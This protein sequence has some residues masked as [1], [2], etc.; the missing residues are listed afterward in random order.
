MRASDLLKPAPKRGAAPSEPVVTNGSLPGGVSLR[1]QT[2]RAKRVGLWVLVGLLALL[3]VRGLV[4]SWGGPRVVIRDTAAASSRFPNADEQA[5]AA[6]F[7]MAWLTFSPGED[8][9]KRADALKGM[10]DPR[11]DAE[12][13]REVPD[14]GKAMRAVAAWPAEATGGCSGRGDCRGA[15]KVQVLTRVQ[16]H[17]MATLYLG[18]PIARSSGGALVV[19]AVPGFV[20]PPAAAKGLPE[21]PTQPLNDDAIEGLV[22]RFLPVFLSGKPVLPELLLC[23]S[24]PP[25]PLGHAWELVE[26]QSVEQVMV[27]VPGPPS[28]CAAGGPARSVVTTVRARDVASGVVFTLRYTIVVA[29][30]TGINGRWL[31]KQV[32]V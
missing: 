26:V 1:R 5:V 18:V 6:R 19:P 25:V 21:L 17:G 31:V 13:A 24:S 14:G 29:R 2:T 12:S 16:G 11:M 30:E 10:L 7:A 28:G 32:K 15:V 4:S 20:S 9:S 22:G 8:S 3:S 23:P 27:S